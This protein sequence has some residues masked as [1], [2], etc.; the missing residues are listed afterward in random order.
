MFGVWQRDVCTSKSK[1]PC[2]FFGRKVNWR[3]SAREEKGAET[4]AVPLPNVNLFLSLL[5][6]K[7]PSGRN[8]ESNSPEAVPVS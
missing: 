3:E 7:V 1:S 2:E 8:P 6:S 4:A 5:S